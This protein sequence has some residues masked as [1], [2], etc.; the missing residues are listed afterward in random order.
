LQKKKK[1][2]KKQ[3]KK[4]QKENDDNKNVDKFGFE[5]S[6]T[7]AIKPEGVF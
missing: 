5:A 2:K 4:K 7:L 3:T 6:L 1:N